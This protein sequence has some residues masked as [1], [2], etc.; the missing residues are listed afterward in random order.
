MSHSHPF[1]RT[2]PVST[3]SAEDTMRMRQALL[4]ELRNDF[5]GDQRRADSASFQ[6]DLA[7]WLLGQGWVTDWPRRFEE[8]D[9]G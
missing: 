3:H 2:F 4:D 1:R 7:D 5:S 8:E 9:E 6:T